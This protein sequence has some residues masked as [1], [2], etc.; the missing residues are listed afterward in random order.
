[1]HGEER[2]AI[3]PDETV[4]LPSALQRSSIVDAEAKP[5]V[6][7]GSR[8]VPSEPQQ[9]SEIVFI[10][11]SQKDTLSL[12][13]LSLAHI[14]RKGTEATSRPEVISACT[15]RLSY[16]VGWSEVPRREQQ[17]TTSC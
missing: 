9:R 10:D 8:R 5:L 4:V 15:D 1:T 6:L 12:H 3:A 17:W 2:S 11:R 7:A 13:E 16:G 14:R